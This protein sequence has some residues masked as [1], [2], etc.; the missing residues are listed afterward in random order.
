MFLCPSELK[1]LREA[2]TEC[3]TARVVHTKKRGT[4]K[5]N[6]SKYSDAR[7]EVDSL[8]ASLSK[9]PRRRKARASG[10]RTKENEKLN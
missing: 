2:K 6:T 4:N 9:T 8:V 10:T 1:K 7:R 5:T 3:D